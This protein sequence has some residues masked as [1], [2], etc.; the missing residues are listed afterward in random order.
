MSGTETTAE[1]ELLTVSSRIEAGPRPGREPSRL[2]LGAASLA[3]L[4]GGWWLLAH[5]GWVPALF[6][7][8][9]EA[10]LGKLFVVAGQGFMDATLWQ[11]LEASLQR[12]ALA[13]SAAVAVGVPLGALM[14]RSQLAQGL[15]DPMLEAYR[16]VPPLAYLPLIVIWFGIG[17]LSKV[18]L[19]FL[20]I[21]APVAIA[22]RHGV[23]QVSCNRLRAAQ[24]LGANR[25]QLLW[26]VVLPEALPQILTGIRIGLGAG[27]STLVAAELVAA[28]R[29]LG[30]MVQSAAQFL[31]TDVVVLGILVIAA[32]AFALE[33]GLRALQDRLA[34]WHGQQD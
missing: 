14:G 34:P 28:T 15:L 5:S 23:A 3:L 30:F 19:I 11:H 6:L 29:G 21:L 4:L 12:I 16:P 18:L 8:A 22:T 9:P 7:P 20:A 33:L 13:L 24:S 25:S 1:R 26:L 27:W 10:V 2:W 17:E 32:V 31:V